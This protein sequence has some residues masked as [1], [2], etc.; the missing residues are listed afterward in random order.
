MTDE[1]QAKALA[2]VRE[3]H[4]KVKAAFEVAAA[5]EDVLLEKVAAARNV[6]AQ[7]DAIAEQV[8]MQ[9]PN[10]IR[11][12]KPRLTS[13]TTVAVKKAARRKM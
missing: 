13:K 10:A 3:A 11:K 6:S 1:K 4:L 5:A 9:Q 12:F 7:W 2:E 8:E